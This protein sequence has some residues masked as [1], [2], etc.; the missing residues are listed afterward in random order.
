VAYYRKGDTENAIKDINE[1]IRLKPTLG[2]AYVD[3]GAYYQRQGWHDKALAD[4]NEAI[5]L[6]P[7]DARAYCDRGEL[8]DDL[9]HQPDKA[10]ADYNQAIRLAPNFQRAYFNRGVQFLEQHDYGRAIA[11]FT[12]AIQLAPNDLGAYASR[13]YA[14]AKQGDRAH[15]LADATVALKLK[16]TTAMYLAQAIDLELRAIAYKILGQPE[17]A[18]R[19]LREAVRLASRE[20]LAKG[21]L[22]WFLATCPEERFR[23]GA[24]AVSTAKKACEMS[25]WK[26]SASIDTLAVACAEAG[27]FD[28][29]TKY[30]KQAINDPSLSPQERDERGKRLALFQERKAFHEDLSVIGKP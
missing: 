26:R 15:A 29:A 16:P 21:A 8:E 9:L 10:L 7:R 11:D 19:D 25:R 18:L 2:P 22:A 30:E 4:F 27:D 23:N 12:R 1:V 3:R 17:L 20:P 13:A 6:G 28:Q 5:R 24:E 14:Y